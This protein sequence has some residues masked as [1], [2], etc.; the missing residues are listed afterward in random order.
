MRV[1]VRIRRS[2]LCSVTLFF[3]LIGAAPLQAE[4]TPDDIQ[5]LNEQG[6]S[7]GWTFT[8]GLNEATQYSIEQLCGL[9]LPDNWQEEVGPAPKVAIS[10]D[11]PATFD[12]RE[13]GG[14]SSRRP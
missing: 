5:A 3:G 10:G 7:E 14:G 12:W 8:V 13:R 9:K 6:Q 1:S 4:L 2:I 11:L